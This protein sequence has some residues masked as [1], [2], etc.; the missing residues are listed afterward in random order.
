[1]V[2]EKQEGEPELIEDGLSFNVQDDTDIRAVSKELFSSEDIDVKTEVSY[3][4]INMI[5][6]MRFLQQK[7]DMK[8]IDKT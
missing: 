5:S 1:M 6:K 7:F 2:V 8:N 4:E 3:D